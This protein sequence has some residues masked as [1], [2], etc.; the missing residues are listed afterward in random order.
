[1]NLVIPYVVLKRGVSYVESHDTSL[2]LEEKHREQGLPLQ[3]TTAVIKPKFIVQ[4][5]PLQ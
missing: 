1:M 2:I 5:V 4:S 3:P